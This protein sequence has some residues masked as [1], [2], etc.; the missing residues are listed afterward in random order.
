MSFSL[1]LRN[2]FQNA[3]EILMRIYLSPEKTHGWSGDW[4]FGTIIVFSNPAAFNDFHPQSYRKSQNQGSY[5]P[6][7][8]F[9]YTLMMQPLQ[10]LFVGTS[11]NPGAAVRFGRGPRREVIG[12]RTIQPR[13]LPVKDCQLTIQR[14]RWKAPDYSGKIS[15]T[16]HSSNAEARKILNAI[17]QISCHTLMSLVVWSFVVAREHE[18]KKQNCC[19]EGY[20]HMSCIDDQSN[21]QVAYGKNFPLCYGCQSAACCMVETGTHSNVK[22]TRSPLGSGFLSTLTLQSI[23]DII[24]SPN[25]KTI[26]FNNAPIPEAICYLF[27]Y[28]GLEEYTWVAQ[29]II[30]IEWSTHL[31]SMSVN[32]N[33]LIERNVKH[34]LWLIRFRFVRTS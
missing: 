8:W 3:P 20:S 9:S 32:E 33:T 25:W 6:P 15:D 30:S 21:H 12:N 14:T 13:C 29:T 7:T 10:T 18:T 23:S 24:P 22:T 34:F 2:Q 16:I 5:S 4:A 26:S 1:S 11:V 28:N 17:S 27:M 31:Y 19:W